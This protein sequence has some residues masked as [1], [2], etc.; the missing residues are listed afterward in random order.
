MKGFIQQL[1]Q[2]TAGC[3]LV[4]SAAAQPY[5]L[6]Q[7]PAVGPFLNGALPGAALPVNTNWTCAVAFT[8]LTFTNPTGLTFMP[9]TS[10]LVVWEREGR[11][12]SF[13]NHAGASVKKLVL[14]LSNQCQ[15]WHEC[16]LLSVAF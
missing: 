7:R 1:G 4:I 8:N 5:G 12:Y 14:D 6:S 10:N 16:G 9:G 11:V 3:C 15:G 13:T 2:L